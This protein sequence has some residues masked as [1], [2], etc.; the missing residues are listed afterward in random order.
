MEV[1]D[2]ENR[3]AG[4]EIGFADRCRIF[5]FF[6][7]RVDLGRIL[8]ALGEQGFLLAGKDDRQVA[9]GQGSRIGYGDARSLDGDDAVDVY[10]FE[11]AGELLT[12]VIDEGRIDLLVQK[13]I[14]LQNPVVD[15][16][17]IL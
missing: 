15:D 3:F 10:V 4:V 11:T 2:Y 12:D 9:H 8:F 5:F 1:I 17:A 6:R 16:Q 13:V 14:N 7:I